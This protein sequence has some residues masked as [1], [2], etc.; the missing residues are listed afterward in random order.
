MAVIGGGSFFPM[1]IGAPVLGPA[2]LAE[3][4]LLVAALFL[5][6]VSCWLSWI[7]HDHH[8]RGALPPLST[9]S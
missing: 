9:P 7:F 5:L 2:V 3:S 8:L 4:R 6:L 1:R